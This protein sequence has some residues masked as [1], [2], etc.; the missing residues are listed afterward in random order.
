RAPQ[1]I[2]YNPQFIVNGATR[3]DIKQGALG[4]CW[5][6]AAIASLTLHPRL[7]ARVV[8]EGQSFSDGYAGIFHFQF[9]QFG[10]WVDVVIDDLLPTQNNKLAFL[11][12]TDRNEFWSALLEKAYAKLNGSYEALKGGSI[13]EAM[14]DFT[15]GVFEFYN[16]KKAPPDL[17]RIMRKGLEK[18][19]MMGC[20]ID[21]G[22]TFKYR[23]TPR[24]INMSK[25][26]AT[27]RAWSSGIRRFAERFLP[28]RLGHARLLASSG[29]EI[30]SMFDLEARLPNG[31]VKGHAYSITG[32]DQVF[33]EGQD[34]RL[35]RIR[36]PWGEV[37]WN[38]AWSDNSWE[39]RVVD[40]SERRRLEQVRAEDG[41]FWMSFS[42]FK[43]NFS[44]MEICNLSPDTLRT[45]SGSRHWTVTAHEGRWLRGCTA[46]GC[47][48]YAGTFWTNPQF[49]LRLHEEDDDPDDDE[50]ACSFIVAL[51]QKNMRRQ[52]RDLLTIGYAIY[53]IPLKA[54][55]GCTHLPGEFFVRNSSRARS[56]NFI[57][58]REVSDR[59]RLPPGHYVIVPS[60]YEPHQEADFLLRVYCE[61]MNRSRGETKHN[62]VSKGRPIFRGAFKQVSNLGGCGGPNCYRVV[63]EHIADEIL[64]SNSERVGEAVQPSMP[65]EVVETDEDR[66][67]TQVFKKLAGEDMEISPRELQDL[68]NKVTAKL[69]V[70]KSDGFSLYACQSMVALMDSDGS[71][72]L[73]LPEFKL[74]WEKIKMWQAIFRKYDEDRSGTMS[75]Y[76]MRAALNAAGFHLNNQMYQLIT[77][78]YAD[79]SMTIK[80]NDYITCMVR[81]EAMFRIF[82]ALDKDKRG[83]IR[84]GLGLWLQ[85]TMYA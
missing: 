30:T 21:E 15:G 57:N 56:H 62:S 76:E 3:T 83:V 11:H 68:L 84:L 45:Q 5:L 79:E 12:S 9:W 13:A 1:E 17:Y 10:E 26:T 39:W 16:L 6:L 66:R 49:H 33:F 60:T 44:K 55:P 4:D 8:P 65:V 53:E 20:S 80:F 46:G 77:M 19:S 64:K 28:S 34:V 69:K 78:R 24:A 50:V 7:L 18:A 85:L 29:I 67:F 32:L 72:K 73:G 47:R 59:F 42:D 37:E 14:E 36:N 75:S 82:H 2:C 43:R 40:V 23:S 48:N 71:G 22:S 38:G 25:M 27:F 74:L 35:V 41:E 51:M 31:L 63:D 70:F 81:L 52:K 61:K 58:L 54:P